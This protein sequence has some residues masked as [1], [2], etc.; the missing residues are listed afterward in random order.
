M[1]LMESEFEL[2]LQLSSNI[3]QWIFKCFQVF[4][5]VFQTH[6]SSVLSVFRRMLQMFHLD[7]SK[8][9]RVLQMLQR[10]QWLVDKGLPLGF[11][12]YLAPS[13]CGAPRP[14]LSLPLPFH[15][16]PFPSLRL[17]AAVQAQ[18]ET[19]GRMRAGGRGGASRSSGAESEQARCTPQSRSEKWTATVVVPS[20]RPG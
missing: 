11:G 14:L 5:Q 10:C 20:E 17:A 6:V 4:L 19:E 9:D 12:S 1:G 8:V 2:F 18:W 13:L 15:S 16:L 3:L 7:V